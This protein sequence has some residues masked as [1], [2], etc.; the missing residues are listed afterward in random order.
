[1]PE[2]HLPGADTGPGDHGHDH[3]SSDQ[4]RVVGDPGPEQVGWEEVGD[5]EEE[6]GDMKERF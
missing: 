6:A 5:E 2:H 1:M 3:V 4:T